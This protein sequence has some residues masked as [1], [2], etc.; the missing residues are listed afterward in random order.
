MVEK[1]PQVSSH[2]EIQGAISNLSLI[3]SNFGP[4]SLCRVGTCGTHQGQVRRSPSIPSSHS[5]SWLRKAVGFRNHG[6]LEKPAVRE[7]L[8]V[9]V[10]VSLHAFYASACEP[11]CPFNIKAIELNSL[12]V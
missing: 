2:L 6:L 3:A 4:A 8:V 11:K 7:K 12:E 10:C 1:M 9:I 5:P